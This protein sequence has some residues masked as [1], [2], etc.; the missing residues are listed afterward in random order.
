MASRSAVTARRVLGS[1]VL[2]AALA[3][4]V[5]ASADD[6]AGEPPAGSA[7]G[8]AT[9]DRPATPPRVTA[10]CI[11]QEIADRLALKRKRRGAIDRVFVKRARHE[12]STVGGYYVSDLFSSTYV[13]GAAY[14]YHMTESTAVELS[15]YLTHADADLM[16]TLEAGRARVLDDD[17]ARVMFGESVLVYS[18]IYGKLRLG[19]A[20]LHFD[21]HADLG[22]GVV[23]APTSRGTTGVAGF[24]M[25]IFL[26]KAVALRIDA[27]DHVFR[28]ELLDRRYLV[29]DLSLTTGLSLFLPLRN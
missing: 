6:Q 29:N 5:P 12:L 9:A 17:Y 24:G 23:D 14:T 13:V 3:W 2:L 10:G 28:Q 7:N 11:D 8:A 25:K 18:P 27:R 16:A 20:I 15:G 1:A 21:L 26:G 22:V 4:A 19:G